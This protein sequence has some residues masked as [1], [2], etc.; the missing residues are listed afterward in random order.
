MIDIIL[1]NCIGL[2]GDGMTWTGTLEQLV[3]EGFIK[4]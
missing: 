1:L 3:E 4:L 2:C